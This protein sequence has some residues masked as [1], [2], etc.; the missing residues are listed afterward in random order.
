MKAA[1]I[2][3][4][5]SYF[6]ATELTNEMLIEQMGGD[7]NPQDIYD[8]TG[9]LSRRIAGE[10]ECSSDLGIKAANKLFETG[11]FLIKK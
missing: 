3:C 10:N 5:A 7:W 4:I 1:S 8:K 9:I 2:Q 11:V 6:P